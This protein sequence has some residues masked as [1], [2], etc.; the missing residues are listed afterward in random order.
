[1]PPER[2]GLNISPQSPFSG[3]IAGLK[4]KLYGV[5]VPGKKMRRGGRGGLVAYLGW[6]TK[7]ALKGE[8]GVR[9]A[10][11]KNFWFRNLV[12]PSSFEGGASKGKGARR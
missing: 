3:T 12:A 4:K 9:E 11:F 5:L 7:I 1:V 10:E 6:E 2:G 8:R